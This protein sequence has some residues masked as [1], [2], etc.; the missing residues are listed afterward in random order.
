MKNDQ[1]GRED[2]LK[3]T[4]ML[5]YPTRRSFIARVAV[6]AAL[7]AV[8]FVFAKNLAFDGAG[9]PRHLPSAHGVVSFHMDQPYF[10]A[11]G[12]AARYDPPSGA[13]SAECAAH[14]KEEAFL[15]SHGYA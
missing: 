13:R 15:C 5:S 1:R 4:I 2:L 8:P 12:T 6:A 11:T 10:D 7:G 9:V 3:S 14:L